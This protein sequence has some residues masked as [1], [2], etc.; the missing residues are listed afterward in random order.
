M[1]ELETLIEIHRATDG[2][3]QYDL[4]RLADL[5]IAERDVRARMVPSATRVADLPMK[6]LYEPQKSTEDRHRFTINQGGSIKLRLSNGSDRHVTI[7][8]KNG[9]FDSVEWD[10]AEET[11]GKSRDAWWV[12]GAIANKIAELEESYSAATNPK[13]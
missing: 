7:I 10:V 3:K 2:F 6:I 5:L 12:R 11:W 13:F 1:N 4:K 9:K 8:F